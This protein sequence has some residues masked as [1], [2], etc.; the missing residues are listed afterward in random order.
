MKNL[1]WSM[2]GVHSWKGMKYEKL[3]MKYAQSACMDGGMEYA[4]NTTN[5]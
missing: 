2:H 3:T 5:I 1:L 4:D